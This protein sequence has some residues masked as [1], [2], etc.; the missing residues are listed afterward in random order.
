MPAKFWPKSFRQA[1]HHLVLGIHLGHVTH[2]GAAHT[3][4]AGY[5]PHLDPPFL[6]FLLTVALPQYAHLAT[7]I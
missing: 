4:T 3:L 2:S 7:D 6:S 5:S 1:E